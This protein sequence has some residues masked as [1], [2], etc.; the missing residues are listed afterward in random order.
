M[1]GTES[2]ST[3]M[4]QSNAQGGS[5]SVSSHAT[6]SNASTHSGS[7]DDDF[8]AHVKVKILP[9]RLGNRILETF[10]VVVMLG[11]F[12][13]FRT[14]TGGFSGK[15]K[16]SSAENLSFQMPS[17]HS[18][19][20][21]CQKDDEDR[22]LLKRS[23]GANISS[24]TEKIPTH[25]PITEAWAE[26]LAQLKKTDP[27][28]FSSGAGT[29]K[30]KPKERD[31]DT[32][33]K[34]ILGSASTSIRKSS[35]GV[36]STSENGLDLLD[37]IMNQQSEF[38]QTMRKSDDRN[39]PDIIIREV[40]KT[41]LAEDAAD[42]TCLEKSQDL[43]AVAQEAYRRFEQTC[44]ESSSIKNSPKS[45]QILPPPPPPPKPAPQQASSRKVPTVGV[46]VAH[47]LVPPPP[48]PPPPPSQPPCKDIPPPPPPRRPRIS[49]VEQLPPPPPPPKRLK[50]VRPP[51]SAKPAPAQQGGSIA[52]EIKRF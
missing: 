28:K 20:L 26:R 43:S 24:K 8:S 21:S 31:S 51:A 17:R 11:T 48:P 30:D 7:S 42:I 10:V 50:P 40:R 22:Y 34:S 47:L 49:A 52:T 25:K 37:S 2:P 6:V 1:V 27:N 29:P 4:S 16:E 41:E 14:S 3:Q 39:S 19:K 45:P 32:R 5:E 36:S 9:K 44:A 15:R 35:V 38:L 33:K 12:D 46:E 18:R 13:Y 23:H